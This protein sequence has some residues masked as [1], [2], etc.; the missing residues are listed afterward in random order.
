MLMRFAKLTKEGHYIPAKHDKLSYGS[1]V[2][3]RAGI[4]DTT[5]W[6]VA[7]AITS[8]IRY[9]TVR[10]QFANT[11][12]TGDK[13]EVQVITYAA[14]RY[15]LYPILAQ[16]YAYIIAGRQLWISYL[17][18]LDDLTKRGDITMLG[19]MHSLS[20][21]LKA[22]TTWDG[23][24]SI[25]EARKSM[26]GHGYSAMSRA[27]HWFANTTPAQTY[28]GIPSRPLYIVCRTNWF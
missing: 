25:E 11:S 5:G 4:P 19:E 24:A 28:E 3:L 7:R 2:A 13:T 16:S 21:A 27:G 15:R 20:S 14:V 10:R 8:A 23:V 12:A 9:C 18:L 26:G 22:L 17:Q 1:M 6:Q